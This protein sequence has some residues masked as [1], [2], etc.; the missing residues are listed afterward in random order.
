MSKK[1]RKHTT[2]TIFLIIAL[3][4]GGFWWINKC[5]NWM[6]ADGVPI[7]MYHAIGE[8][9]AGTP[10]NMTGWYV[11][12]EKFKEQMEYLKKHNYTF[13]TF[14]ELK[15]SKNHKK[16]ILI[17]FDDG[18]ANNMEAFKI[19]KSL[20][21][22]KFEPKATLFMIAS[23][24]NQP[25]YLS[26]NQLKEM[27]GSGIFSI[28]SHTVSHIN[29]T[30]PNINFQLEYGQAK[31]IISNITEKEVYV[32][33]YPFGAFNQNSLKEAKHYYKYA[34]TMGHNRCKLTGDKHALF[35]LKRL[36]V[37]GHDSMWK[38]IF[39]VR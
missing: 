6:F 22:N 26:A 9:P 38:F 23:L 7:L 36:T 16:P 13:I 19:L 37:S 4:F 33:S 27:S 15:K 24:I 1:K 12:K 3:I 5:K 8:P 28:Q 17:T 34:V 31:R 11:S 25:D 10:K 30:E 14:D 2:L 18:Y 39:M 20:K 21:D 29:L 35:Q 32:L